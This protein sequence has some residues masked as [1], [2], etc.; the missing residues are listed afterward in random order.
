MRNELHLTTCNTTSVSYLV[1]AVVAR[2]NKPLPQPEK[3]LTTFPSGY[4]CLGHPKVKVFALE[5]S[6]NVPHATNIAQFTQILAEYLSDAVCS[7]YNSCQ[8]R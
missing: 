1:G 3:T 2:R 7:V 6:P 5:S 4:C 8:L